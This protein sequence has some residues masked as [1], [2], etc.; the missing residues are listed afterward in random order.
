MELYYDQQRLYRSLITIF[1]KIPKMNPSSSSCDSPPGYHDEVKTPLTL[2]ELPPAYEEESKEFKH[3]SPPA[4]ANWLAGNTISE[5]PVTL[6]IP[7]GSKTGAN[8]RWAKQECPGGIENIVLLV[9]FSASMSDFYGIL[10]A[11]MRVGATCC[12]VVQYGSK[13]SNVTLGEKGELVFSNGDQRDGMTNFE[14]AWEKVPPETELVIFCTDGHHNQGNVEKCREYAEKVARI[15]P[16]HLGSNVNKEQLE[17]FAKGKVE[18]LPTDLPSGFRRTPCKN[19]GEMFGVKDNAGEMFVDFLRKL[20]GRLTTVAKTPGY[21]YMGN[22]TPD[23]LSI[24]AEDLPIEEKL[25]LFHTLVHMYRYQKDGRALLSLST[26]QILAQKWFSKSGDLYGVQDLL[27]KLRDAAAHKGVEGAKQNVNVGGVSLEEL[28]AM[29][30]MATNVH[31]TDDGIM[32]AAQEAKVNNP[33]TSLKKAANKAQAKMHDN[34][35]R[36]NWLLKVLYDTGGI[37]DPNNTKKIY[38]VKFRACTFD[39]TA[40]SIVGTNSMAFTLVPDQN[41]TWPLILEPTSDLERQSA[42]LQLFLLAVLPVENVAYTYKTP[43]AF[44]VNVLSLNPN[45]PHRDTLMKLLMFL[46]NKRPELKRQ[47]CAF[48]YSCHPFFLGTISSDHVFSGNPYAVTLAPNIE[49]YQK[50]MLIAH[51]LFK[52]G[53][54]WTVG[55]VLGEVHISFG[56][57]N[58]KPSPSEVDTRCQASVKTQFLVETVKT[59]DNGAEPTCYTPYRVPDNLV[60]G[61]VDDDLD[62]AIQ[63]VALSYKHLKKEKLNLREMADLLKNISACPQGDNSVQY[64]IVEPTPFQ[65]YMLKQFE[66]MLFSIDDLL[67]LW[68]ESDS[69]SKPK[70]VQQLHPDTDLTNR[71]I[72][73]K[74]VPDLAYHLWKADRGPACAKI[75]PML[76]PSDI[77]EKLLKSVCLDDQLK[78]TLQGSQLAKLLSFGKSTPLHIGLEFVSKDYDLHLA[79]IRSGII[80]T[81][82]SE[83]SMG[84]RPVIDD[85]ICNQDEKEPTVESVKTSIHPTPSLPPS[86]P[87][88]ILIDEMWCLNHI[89][90]AAVEDILSLLQRK[91]PPK[92]LR[93]F[94]GRFP[95]LCNNQ[96]DHWN[97]MLFSLGYTAIVGNDENNPAWN[98]MKPEERKELL[99][100]R[101]EKVN[102]ENKY[103]YIEELKS[104]RVQV[105]GSKR[106]ENY[107]R[108]YGKYDHCV[109]KVKGRLTLL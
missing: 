83:L 55:E 54:I 36:R 51:R 1:F 15:L 95:N 41:G 68:N 98:S 102:W 82:G 78:G 57:N 71:V 61:L 3:M 94:Q 16:I 48:N 18:N 6:H 37:H 2:N 105:N 58:S 73:A 81:V 85:N 40:V 13:A 87:M 99:T 60:H 46:L 49:G 10:Y 93:F 63:M 70:L 20:L 72:W 17:A 30:K 26:L 19:G 22:N 107:I 77:T 5:M 8:T 92:N 32:I 43:I 103:V 80:T 29:T 47:W 56:S 86:L 69:E 12:T 67:T 79:L 108:K 106:Y 109:D 21:R 9:D 89:N 97:K 84:G 101:F 28:I 50:Y 23:G 4:Y 39:Q 33:T 62:Q 74:V 104:R 90:S 24:K 25:S 88:T 35:K 96:C 34:V 44:I 64:C 52:T 27:V 7:N 14:A 53:Q 76:Q 100:E 38:E 75:L 59:N 65:L 42:L 66:G 45:L 31:P 11:L 91:S